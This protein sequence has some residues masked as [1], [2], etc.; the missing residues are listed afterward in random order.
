[1]HLFI[2]IN[3]FE[4][5]NRILKKLNPKTNKFGRRSISSGF[6]YKAI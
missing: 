4:E 2:Y 1:M 6:E 5:K 3:T